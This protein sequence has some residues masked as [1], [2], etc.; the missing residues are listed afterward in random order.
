MRSTHTPLRH[1]RYLSLP[2]QDPTRDRAEI[3]ARP[4]FLDE[5]LAAARALS[6]DMPCVR[7]DFTDSG[8]RLLFGEFTLYPN[9]GL[10]RWDPPEADLILGDLVDLPDPGSLR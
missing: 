3:P 5:L 9:A 2:F 7:V 1:S 6:R 10:N 8:G 4:D